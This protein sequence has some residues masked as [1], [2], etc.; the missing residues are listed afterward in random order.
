MKVTIQFLTMF[1]LGMSATAIA[2]VA[3]IGF[4]FDGV[5]TD[6][7]GVPV[8]QTSASFKLEIRDKNGLCAFYSEEHLAK[9]LALGAFSI[10][11]G[12]GSSR[13][14]SLDSSQFLTG[15]V[16]S[17]T[18]TVAPSGC[19]PVTINP[20]DSRLL[21][22]FYDL[23]S[24]YV[25]FTPD[26]PINSA[27]YALVTDSISGKKLVDLVQTKSDSST[28]LTQAS[29][30][31]I[32][33]VLNFS[34]LRNLLSGGGTSPSFS[35]DRLTNLGAP[36]SIADA[37]N[38][39]YVDSVI[40]GKNLDLSGIGPALG[41]GRTIV[42]DSAAAKWVTAA[43]PAAP[44]SS[45]NGR[46]GAVTLSAADIPG[47]N[48]AVMR[49]T[50]GNL[51]VIDGANVT[52]VNAVRISGNRVATVVP[53]DNDVLRFNSSLSTWMPTPAG[54]GGISGLTGD[55]SASG[56]GVVAASINTGAVISSKLGTGYAVNRLVM[57]NATDGGSLIFASCGNFNQV[58]TWTATGWQC[59]TPIAQVSPGAGILGGGNSGNVSIAVDVGTTANKIVQLDSSARLP[60]V[61]GG[62][63]SNIS[64]QKIQ[65]RPISPTSPAVGQVLGWNGS[66]W[67]P[68]TMA[69][70]ITGL[71]GDIVTSV[72]SGVMTATINPSA[73]TNAKIASGAVTYSKISTATSPGFN[74]LIATSPT[75]ANA[76][77]AFQCS[78]DGDTLKWTAS[79]GWSCMAPSAGTNLLGGRAVSTASP[80][81]ESLLMWNATFAQWEPAIRPMF[82]FNPSGGGDLVASVAGS[83]RMRI[84][85]SGNVGIGTSA[86][87]ETLD[88]F[89]GSTSASLRLRSGTSSF[90][91]KVPL[92]ASNTV[93]TMP[94]NNGA[95]GQVLTSDGAGNLSW[96]NSSG[97]AWTMSGGSLYYSGGKVGIGTS[98]PSSALEIVNVSGIASDDTLKVRAATGQSG[99]LT[100]WFN[101]QGA[102]VASMAVSGTFN[103]PNANLNSLSVTGGGLFS[104][105]VGIGTSSATDR[106][107]V[108]GAVKAAQF[109]AKSQT[110]GTGTSIVDWDMG[111]SIITNFNCSTPFTFNNLRDGGSYVLVVNDVGTTTCS[112]SAT[113][114]G[115]DGT[116][117]TYKFKPANGARTAS[118]ST[119]YRLTRIGTTVFV[120]WDSGFN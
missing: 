19:S 82:W 47:F 110:P 79:G 116:T 4:S 25:A 52:N 62:S 41:D 64:A 29:L 100:S 15:S 91:L 35:G 32:F 36:I 45:I 26:F 51:P 48:Q 22:V 99:N 54:P 55:I 37:A 66:Q 61:D 68:S 76:L 65:A 24:G 118:T 120:S 42:W 3:P 78:T 9:S 86:P 14:N 59:S 77:T 114:T 74:R 87:S 34:R 18:G 43:P 10:N 85:A 31:E 90:T 44:V 117:L 12:S 97:G 81:S 112:F 73:V 39:G 93:W 60:A 108:F 95:S 72:G 105:N 107:E 23:G 102:I 113:S 80:S 30:E 115:V 16:F 69:S 106:L 40:G 56:S 67:E 109:V 88:I 94:S 1:F 119:V 57:T 33:S 101:A 84:T 21:R 11:V 75:D 71:T 104:G 46:T 70:G 27:P 20:G 50:N 6:A 58:L 98:T 63:L 2:Q 17:A 53:S 13:L 89:T 96:V 28:A 38:K 103:A 7:S 5:L 111:A 49:D 92:S 83:E 8:T